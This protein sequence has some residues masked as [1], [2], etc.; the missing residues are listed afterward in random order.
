MRRLGTMLLALL[1]LAAP[2]LAEAPAVDLMRATA[3]LFAAAQE[4]MPGETA[5]D[6]RFETHADWVSA[7]LQYTKFDSTHWLGMIYSAQT[8]ALVDWDEL[9]ADGDAAAA[10]IER[11]AGESTYDNAYAERIAVSPV[12]RDSF[13][14]LGEELV[15][16][17][18]PE[19]FAYFSGRAGA[20]SFYA[21]ELEGLLRPEVPLRTGDVTLASTALADALSG[22]ALPG[23]LAEWTVGRPMQEAADAMDLVDV[24]DIKDGLAVWRFEASEMR[25]A[26]FLSG[27]EDDQVGTAKV[28]GIYTERI[29][30]SGLQTGVATRDAC[31]AALGEPEAAAQVSGENA[32]YAL[33]PQGE[34]LRWSDGVHALLLHFVEGVLHSV[35]VCDA[36]MMDG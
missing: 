26:A 29:D 13:A 18:P 17:Y 28:A 35:T 2:A 36:T 33:Y 24:P 12:P 22:G 3:V 10:A 27:Q 6:T 32:A 1:L 21:Y 15:V 11:I 5:A 7:V 16:Y 9:F 25:G 30:F 34:R 19:Q 8:D 23:N 14:I 31:V 20:F 4:R